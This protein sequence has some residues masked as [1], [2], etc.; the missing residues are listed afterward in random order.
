[1][2]DCMK[3]NISVISIPI[4]TYTLQPTNSITSQGTAAQLSNLLEY[5]HKYELVVLRA[6]FCVLIYREALHTYITI[7]L[8]QYAFEVGLFSAV[9]P[10]IIFILFGPIS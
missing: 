4:H 7:E 3:C 1:M 2:I 9:D 10:Y 8:V 6:I 5:I